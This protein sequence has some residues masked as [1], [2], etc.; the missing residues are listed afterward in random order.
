MEQKMTFRGRPKCWVMWGGVDK[1]GDWRPSSLVK[2][3]LR[4]EDQDFD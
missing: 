4:Q 2:S 1:M 3:H